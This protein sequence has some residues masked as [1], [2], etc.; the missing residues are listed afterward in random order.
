[1]ESIYAECNIEKL[2][3]DC[4]DE[5]KDALIS[6]KFNI[7]DKLKTGKWRDIQNEFEKVFKNKTNSFK[8]QLLASLEQL[9]KKIK[10]NY[11]NF[12]KLINRFLVDSIKPQQDFILV[13]YISNK[14]GRE[15]NIAQS[16]DDIIFEIINESKECTTWAKSK[17]IW[18]WI[19]SKL[20]S[21]EYLN[22][23]IDFMIISSCKKIKEISENIYQIIKNFKME[24]ENEINFKKDYIIEEL[25]QKKIDKEKEIQMDK[26][27]KTKEWEE[28]KKLFEKQKEE[29]EKLYN[30]Y[31]EL[32]DDLTKLRLG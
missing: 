29:W 11:D 17:D 19:N 30:E 10:D 3:K 1:M 21:K 28:D 24:I 9:S 6:L 2:F 5:I 4:L 20:Y 27:K 26:E 18:S 22:K 32:R 7:A 14:L 25:E 31:R 12:Y 13:N 16:I 15:N 23:I 8:D